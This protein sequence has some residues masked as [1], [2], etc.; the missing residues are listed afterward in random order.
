[1]PAANPVCYCE[2]LTEFDFDAYFEENPIDT[3]SAAEFQCG[4]VTSNEFTSDLRQGERSGCRN[5]CTICQSS[6]ALCYYVAND[7]ESVTRIGV[8]E[9]FTIQ[10]FISI[11]EATDDQAGALIENRLRVFS[12]NYTETTCFTL[13]P[14]Q[15]HRVPYV[16]QSSSAIISAQGVVP[17]E[18]EGALF[19]PDATFGCSVSVDGIRVQFLPIR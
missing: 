17:D 4:W 5:E 3:V 8:T 11:G 6:P 14:Y 9:P 19:G 15:I 16:S 13:Q 7:E 2:D 12:T 10:D 18:I 1:M